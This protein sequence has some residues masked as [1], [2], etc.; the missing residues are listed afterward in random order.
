MLCLNNVIIIIK[1]IYLR[2]S[3]ALHIYILN[4]LDLIL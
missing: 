1:I 2:C 4:I 3:F